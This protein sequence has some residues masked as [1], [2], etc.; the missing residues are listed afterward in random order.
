MEKNGGFTEGLNVKKLLFFLS[1]AL[2]ILSTCIMVSAASVSAPTL[3][4][5][6]TRTSDSHTVSWSR[7]TGASGY[8]VA[9]KTPGSSYKNVGTITKGTTTKAVV[10]NRA[11]NKEYT[12]CVKA[13]KIT[14]GKRVGSKWSSTKTATLNKD[15]AVYGK[16]VPYS[17]YGRYYKSQAQAKSNMTTVQVKTWDFANGKN[18]VKI[19]RTWNL[20]VN[21]RLARTVKKMF[22]ELYKSSGKFP[23]HDLGG[24]RWDGRRSEHNDGTAI[25]INPDENYM[26]QNGRIVAGSFWRPGKNPYSIPKNGELAKIFKKYGFTQGIWSSS[27]DYMHFSYFGT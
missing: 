4:S 26:I 18:G 15:V 17:S 9:C 12:Y 19:T 11:L 20:T 21:K 5:V 14:N 22:N 6:V 3:K 25:D 10:Y 8:I 2:M 27:Q 24:W 7:V 13:Y 1:A 23:I 16:D